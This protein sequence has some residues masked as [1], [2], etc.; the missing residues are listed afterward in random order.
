M[1]T[2]FPLVELIVH[3]EYLDW[4]YGVKL[5]EIIRWSQPVQIKAMEGRVAFFADGEK[6]WGSHLQ[7]AITGISEENYNTII[8]GAH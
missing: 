5:T 8:E 6:N 1:K 2:G 7:G 3:K 4:K